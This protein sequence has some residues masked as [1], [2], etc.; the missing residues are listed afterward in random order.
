MKHVV[1]MD[2][3]DAE[4]YREMEESLR[5]SIT[6]IDYNPETGKYIVKVQK[7]KIEQLLKDFEFFNDLP[8]EEVE[9]IV[10]F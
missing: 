4:R 8:A 1:I 5:D 6:S 10:W 9:K 3:Y 2:P 7:S